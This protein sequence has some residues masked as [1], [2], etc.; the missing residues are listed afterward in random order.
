MGMIFF[1]YKLFYAKCE[2][3]VS[4]IANI[5]AVIHLASCRG[6]FVTGLTQT[7]DSLFEIDE[8]EQLLHNTRLAE[9][10][11]PLCKSNQAEPPY[12]NTLPLQ[13]MKRKK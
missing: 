8:V 2:K 13:Q 4:I 9:T 5:Y 11:E 7:K 1:I 10:K 6:P 12:I 3:N